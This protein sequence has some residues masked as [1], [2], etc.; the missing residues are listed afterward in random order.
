MYNDGKIDIIGTGDIKAKND[1]STLELS[2][3][4]KLIM[5]NEGTDYAVLY[6]KL[7]AEFNNLKDKFNDLITSYNSHTHSGVT[8][9][10]SSTGTPSGVAQPSTADITQCKQAAVKL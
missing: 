6:S 10:S 2:N 4:E 1:K 8:S 9:G 3:T 7:E 5:L